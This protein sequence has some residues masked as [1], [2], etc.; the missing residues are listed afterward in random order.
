[1]FI[2]LVILLALE[3]VGSRADPPNVKDFTPVL[4]KEFEFRI[5]DYKTVFV[6]RV[7][8][9]QK[10]G[11]PN[12]FVR[13][14]YRQKALV[15]ERAKENST[16]E[17]SGRRDRNLSNLNYHRKEE[18]EAIDRVQQASDAFAYVQEQ[19]VR[20]LRTGQDIRTGHRKIWLLDSSGVWVY[21]IQPA[22]EKSALKPSLFSEPSKADPKKPILVGIKFTLGGGTHIVRIDQDDVPAPVEKKEEAK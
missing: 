3:V 9:Y 19:T 16:T 14:Y 5:D 4:S 1:M 20:D 10:L 21:F 11:D 8:D 22:N 15:S 13:V 7:I 12:E 18:A 17:A 6:G 2:A